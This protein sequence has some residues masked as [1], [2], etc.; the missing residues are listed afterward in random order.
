MPT[1]LLLTIV[2]KI[3]SRVGG[4]TLN[5]SKGSPQNHRLFGKQPLIKSA[6][7]ISVKYHT[8]QTQHCRYFPQF[9][10]CV[11]YISSGFITL[12]APL[13]V[14]LGSTT[15]EGPVS[16]LS[17][18]G[19]KS[20]FFVPYCFCSSSSSPHFRALFRQALTQAGTP[21]SCSRPGSVQKLHLP[22]LPVSGRRTG[23]L[24]GQLFTQFRQAIHFSLSL[25]TTPS[26]CFT[27]APTGQT[28]T[29]TGLA[30]WLQALKSNIGKHN[31]RNGKSW[32]SF[33][34][35]F[36]KSISHSVS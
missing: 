19:A 2:G 28:S 8:D 11:H 6:L 24:Y 17:A 32:L 13:F 34:A 27:L 15:I 21:F 31:K 14:L 10:L 36:S 16:L 20:A 12:P 22:V 3:E 7:R 30:Q 5:F 18:S 26:A 23:T 35:T 9:N 33:G 29:Q 25:N 1:R 4:V